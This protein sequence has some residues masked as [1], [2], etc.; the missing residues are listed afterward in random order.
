MIKEINCPNALTLL[1]LVLAP[2]IMF[3]IIYSRLDLAI[4]F[5]IIAEITDL[6]D[7]YIARKFKK[8]TRF[9]QILDPI[10]DKLLFAFIIYGFLIRQAL[11]WGII[12]VSALILLYSVLYYFFVKKKMKVRTLGKI[13]IFFHT[14]IVIS[15]LVDFSFKWIL[16]FIGIILGIATLLDYIIKYRQTAQK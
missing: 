2:I 7:G 6:L 4:I 11:Y 8:T 1:R 10:V 14:L 16:L 9:G 12:L 5:F 3:L 15:F 13:T